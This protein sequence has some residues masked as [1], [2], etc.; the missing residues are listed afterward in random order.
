M[1]KLL[2]YFL[3]LNTQPRKKNKMLEKLLQDSKKEY[4]YMQFYNLFP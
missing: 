3:I 4:N 2:S 1:K